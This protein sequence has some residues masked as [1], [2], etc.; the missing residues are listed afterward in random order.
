MS[1]LLVVDDEESICWGLARLGHDMGHEVTVASS[2]EEALN[3]VQ[4]QTYDAIVLDV[5]LPGMDGLTAMSELRRHV[6]CVPIVVITA[7]GDLGTAVDAVR[8]GAFEYII[9]PFDRERLQQV[10][11]RALDPRS[12]VPAD[13]GSVAASEG[14]VGTTP[15]MQEVFNRIA[16]AAASDASV[17][18]RGES[19][20]GKELAA[21]AIHKFSPRGDGPFVAVNVASLSPALAESE[22]FGHVRGAF[23]GAEQARTGLLVKANRGTLFLD[24]VADIPLPTQVKLLRALENGEVL[25]VGSDETIRTDLRVISAT[26][27]DLPELIGEGRFR[28]DLYFRLLTF[29]IDLPA[30]R[31]RRA[32]IREL[33]KYFVERISR[34][35]PRGPVQLSENALEELERRDW[36]GNVRELRNAIEHAVLVARGSCIMPE[37]I[38]PPVSRSITVRGDRDLER[39]IQALLTQWTEATLRDPDATEHVYDRLLTLVEPPVLRA[40]LRNQ[41]GQ[42]AASARV[43]G[44]HRTTIKKKLDQYGLSDQ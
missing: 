21:R 29:Q 37:H 38:P 9:K 14:F 39:E 19:G 44:M 24:E 11:G 35:Q 3:L 16:I 18:L 7:Y 6:G 43:L 4:R 12:H 15:A 17:L 8:N 34:N 31:E 22:L 28:Q 27:R 41:G 33:A 26:H 5:R 10:L 20:T 30:L 2:A 32:D 23:T 36:V 25:P 40:I 13:F 42:C 1:K